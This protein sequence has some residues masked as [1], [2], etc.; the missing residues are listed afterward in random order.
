MSHPKERWMWNPQETGQWKDNMI[1]EH[2]YES[3]KAG[4]GSGLRAGWDLS[5]VWPRAEEAINY[6]GGG[7]S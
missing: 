2:L 7:G 5:P 3:G 4:E 6:S 1:D